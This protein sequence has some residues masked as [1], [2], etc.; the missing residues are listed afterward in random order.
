[1]I[2]LLLFLLISPFLLAAEPDLFSR[3]K[4]LPTENRFSLDGY[5]V[6][7]GAP[8]KGGDG[9]YHLFYSRWP[10]SVGF[11]PGWAIHSEIAYA[12]ADQPQG[13]Y[14]HVNVALP[15]RPLNPKTG[16][17]YW[18]GDATHNPNLLRHPNGKYY[19]Y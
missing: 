13:P 10:K 7:C 8:V 15:A 17:K 18:D 9:K 16:K 4:P 5:H 12:V 11:A 1:M 6:W 2:R 14:R 19:L 3:V